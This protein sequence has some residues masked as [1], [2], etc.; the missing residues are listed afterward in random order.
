MQ[1][2]NRRQDEAIVGKGGIIIVKQKIE[3]RIVRMYRGATKFQKK[4][5]GAYGLLT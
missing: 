4:G 2:R 1:K 5:S 3:I